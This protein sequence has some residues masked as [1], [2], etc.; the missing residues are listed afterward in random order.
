[1]G[2]LVG[3]FHTCICIYMNAIKIKT[4]EKSNSLIPRA[5]KI[6]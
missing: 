3:L 4:P 2:K 6:V 5:I 1:M